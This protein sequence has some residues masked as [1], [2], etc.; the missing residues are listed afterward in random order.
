M[1]YSAMNEIEQATQMVDTEDAVEGL[2][3]LAGAGYRSYIH[4]RETA[5]P[6]P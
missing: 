2:L 5:N 1:K 4:I 3:V 6:L